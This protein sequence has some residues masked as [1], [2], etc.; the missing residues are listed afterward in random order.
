MP[1]KGTWY[2]RATRANEAV[3]SSWASIVVVVDLVWPT[4][5]ITRGFDDDDG[6]GE[7]VVRGREVW[8]ER[9]DVVTFESSLPDL[10][11]S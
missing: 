11:D 7:D 5:A 1:R 3:S 10:G 6:S 8:E 4:W 2:R 9:C